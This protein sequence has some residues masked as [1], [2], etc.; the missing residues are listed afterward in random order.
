MKRIKYQNG[1]SGKVCVE[2]FL[3]SKSAVIDEINDHG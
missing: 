2:D 3:E 1:G